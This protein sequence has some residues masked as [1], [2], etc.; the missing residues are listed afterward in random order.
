MKMSSLLLSCLALF[1]SPV[2]AA[3]IDWTGTYRLE[4]IDVE[5]TTLESGAG[6]KLGLM[7]LNL[8]PTFIATDGINIVTNF[9][10]LGNT[11]YPD[12][13]VGQ[14]F[15]AG[16]DD[17]MNMQLREMY[18]RMDQEYGEIIAGRAPIQFGLGMTYNAGK[19]VFDHWEDTHDMFGY[20]F[21][22]GNL[23]FMPMIGNPSH[24]RNMTEAMIDIDYNNLE[25]ES[26][27]GVFYMTRSTSANQNQSYKFYTTDVNP[28]YTHTSSDA[29]LSTNHTN[30]YF[31]RGW[32]SFKFRMEAGFDSGT[33][34]L[35]T[36][37]NDEVKVNG[38]G[39][40]IEMDFPKP[41]SRWQWTLRTGIASGDNPTT[42]NYEAYHMSRNYDMAFLLFNHPLGNYDVLSSMAQRQEDLRQDC[43]T[44]PCPRIANDEA[45]DEETISNAV[46]LS[47]KITY[48][49]GDKWEWRNILT[50]AQTQTNASRVV[51]NDVEKELGWEWDT[52]VVFRPYERVQWLNELGFFLPGG[53]FKEGSV[54]RDAS[55]TFGFQSKAAIS[56]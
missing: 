51:D 44:Y 5:K 34:G 46:Y 50:Y 56:F 16:H 40:A 17:N 42:A 38:Y 6:K 23:S 35:Q 20:K 25:T 2:F 15:G 13:Q 18:L 21:M 37:K 52:A 29:G 31:A 4:A 48:T 28:D 19:G 24:Y 41:D 33:T 3:S 27:F 1:A 53:A 7:H 55:F 8:N 10:I 47:P 14:Q 26:A 9:E 32:E 43:T 11:M 54:G 45:L 12:S 30:V 39:I 49:F 36:A 22:I